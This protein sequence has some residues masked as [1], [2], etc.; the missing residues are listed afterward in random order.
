MKE[1]K[2]IDTRYVVVREFDGNRSMEE[3]FGA[4]MERQADEEYDR[5]RG[6]RASADGNPPDDGRTA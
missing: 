4:I 5:W 2:N 6:S 3:V 1:K